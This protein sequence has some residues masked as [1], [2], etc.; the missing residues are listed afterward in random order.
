VGDSVVLLAG[1]D[2]EE[3]IVPADRQVRVAE[4]G[5]LPLSSCSLPQAAK[6]P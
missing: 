5:E 6:S 4:L 1:L 3:W 2:D